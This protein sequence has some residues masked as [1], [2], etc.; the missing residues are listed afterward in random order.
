MFEKL[1]KLPKL[2][3][4]AAGSKKW[5]D[6]FDFDIRNITTSPDTISC[7]ISFPEK[8]TGN[9]G[10]IHG[11]ILCFVI[12]SIAGIFASMAESDSSKTILTKSLSVSFLKPV[13][14]RSV[15]TVTVTKIFADEILAKITDEHGQEVTVGRLEMVAK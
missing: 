10:V 5:L 8:L 2:A 13:V 1:F 7:T 12:D 11:G 4:Y 14:P 6:L 3:K 9:D 15:Y